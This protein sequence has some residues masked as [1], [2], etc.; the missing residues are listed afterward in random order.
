MQVNYQKDIN[1]NYVTIQAEK[2]IDMDSY[3]IRML[4][5][6]EI[7]SLV[8]CRIQ[9]VD[10]GRVFCYDVGSKETAE[11]CFMKKKLGRET[12]R[13]LMQGI[14]QVIQDMQAFLLDVNQLVIQPE[15]LYYDRGKNML[16]FCY[17]PGYDHQIQEQIRNF[18]EQIL[19]MID[20]GEPAAVAMGYGMYQKAIEKNFQLEQLKEC[21]YKEDEEQKEQPRTE[22]KAECMEEEPEIKPQEEP[23][24]K[25]K[26][27]WDTLIFS[28]IWTV[29]LL[30]I[31]CLRF[32]GY[33]DFL[34]AP[35]ILG[36]F[37]FVMSAVCINAFLWKKQQKKVGSCGKVWAESSALQA[38]IQW[39]GKSEMDVEQRQDDNRSILRGQTGDRDWI[40]NESQEENE[41]QENQQKQK[42]QETEVLRVKK[43][44]RQA[45]EEKENEKGSVSLDDTQPLP[46]IKL[47]EN[48]WLISKETEKLPDIELT[49]DLTVIGKAGSVDVQILLPTVSRIHAKIWRD[50]EQYYIR[51]LD[52]RNGT[53][54]NG[55][56]ISTKNNCRILPGDEVC[57]ADAGYTFR[58]E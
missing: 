29:A 5:G 13:F 17:F 56:R 11:A 10:G 6:N 7:A 23:E 25:E 2:E 58:C 38:S 28:C 1:H 52:S 50:D 4:L 40:L 18:L 43:I 37:I 57:F 54:V 48:A 24:E 16:Q 35:M 20:H 3:P 39:P 46:V 8:P 19:P 55:N 41:G 21:L 27:P 44:C 34:T 45:K 22:E 33:L 36:I 49:G 9:A 14:I 30:G 26:I 31:C 53:F 15:L 12:I 47:P 51:D 42:K 32:L